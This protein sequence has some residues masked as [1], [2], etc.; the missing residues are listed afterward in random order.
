MSRRKDHPA[1]LHRAV[2]LLRAPRGRGHGPPRNRLARCRIS[3][4]RTAGNRKRHPWRSAHISPSSQPTSATHPAK[5]SSEIGQARNKSPGPP[6]P[7]TIASP[8]PCTASDERKDLSARHNGM[9]RR[10]HQT[11]GPQNPERRGATGPRPIP[12]GTSPTVGEPTEG[13]GKVSPAQSTPAI[14][15]RARTRESISTPSSHPAQPRDRTTAQQRSGSRL[16][17]PRSPPAR[18]GGQGPQCHLA[19]VHATIDAKCNQWLT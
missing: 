15:G 18:T 7:P 14:L 3:R 16:T 17:F 11:Q 2:P 6:A 10:P 1:S 13:V 19:A 4:S 8:R 12:S 9:P 5:P